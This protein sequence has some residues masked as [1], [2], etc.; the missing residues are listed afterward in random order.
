MFRCVEGRK[1][2]VFLD[3]LKIGRGMWKINPFMGGKNLLSS[4]RQQN[5]VEKC[6]L[7]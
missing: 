6:S 5:E 1:G 7:S 3:P 2:S 4:F